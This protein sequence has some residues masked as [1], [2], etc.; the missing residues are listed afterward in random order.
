MGTSKPA[1]T[2]SEVLRRA[3]I[4]S[5]TPYLT[6]EQATGVKRASIMRFATGQTSLRLDLADRLAEHFGLTLHAGQ[7]KRRGG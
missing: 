6:L 7:P 2:M 4:E 3:I 5:G 1:E